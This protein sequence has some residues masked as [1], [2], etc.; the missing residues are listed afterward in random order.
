MKISIRTPYYIRMIAVV[1][2]LCQ[3]TPLTA[4]SDEYM[5]LPNYAE[6]DLSSTC[7]VCGMRVGG[8]LAGGVAYAYWE[9]RLFGFAATLLASGN[10]PQSVPSWQEERLLGQPN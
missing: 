3:A 4:W 5:E 8:E 2:F 6:L 10:S 1:C 9:G 7:P